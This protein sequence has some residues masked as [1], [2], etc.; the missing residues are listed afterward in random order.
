[1]LRRPA[2]YGFIAL[3]LSLSLAASAQTPAPVPTAKKVVT[4]AP[5]E[6]PPATPTAAPAPNSVE[7]ARQGVVVIER[8]GKPLELG[9]VLEGDGR[10]LTAL[11]PLTNGNFLSARYSD[12]SVVPLITSLGLSSRNRSTLMRA[13][14]VCAAFSLWSSLASASTCQ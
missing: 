11:S 7:K 10:V 1:M 13:I 2:P 5:P 4:T 3:W 6:P 8:Q 12:G 9:V 14:K